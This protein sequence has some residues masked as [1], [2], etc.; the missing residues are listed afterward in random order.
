M[1]FLLLLSKVSIIKSIILNVYYVGWHFFKFP[2]IVYRGT[3]IKKMKGE[4]LLSR[5]EFGVLQIGRCRNGFQD[6]YQNTIWNV[7]GKIILEGK[8][9]F[10]V[11]SRIDIGV[12]GRLILGDSFCGSG[13][14]TIICQNSITFGTD[15]LLSWDTLL[16]DSD[17]HH[18][19]E[20]HNKI[21]NPMS[22]SAP[23]SIGNHVWIC[24]GSNVFKGVLIGD[25]CVIA[26][27]SKVTKSFPNSNCLIVNNIVKKDNI[28]WE[29]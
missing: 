9:S 3:Y 1:N 10:G 4:I 6:P 26:S 21:D 27:N 18:I 24:L 13:N 12:G 29:Y 16:I 15:C 14:T 19:T 25:N 28:S 2:I 8:A 5:K 23:I 7:L 17:F 22:V 20:K 11:G